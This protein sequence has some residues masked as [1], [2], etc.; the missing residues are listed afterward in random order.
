MHARNSRKKCFVHNLTLEGIPVAEGNAAESFGNYF[1][2]KIKSNAAR[3]IIL[4]SLSYLE[5]SNHKVYLS[6]VCNIFQFYFVL[7]L[8]NLK[9]LLFPAL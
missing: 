4:E 7:L 2:N 8:F 6:K 1:S 5:F 9:L 3:E